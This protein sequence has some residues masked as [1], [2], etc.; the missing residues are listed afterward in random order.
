MGKLD[1]RK[2]GEKVTFKN[3]TEGVV[4]ERTAKDGHKYK[5]YKFTKGLSKEGMADLRKIR[6]LQDNMGK[7]K[8]RRRRRKE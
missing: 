4:V 1:N 6:S 7:K 5:V 3:G 8:R 2:V